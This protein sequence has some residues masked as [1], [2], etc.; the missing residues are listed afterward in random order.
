MIETLTPFELARMIAKK[1]KSKKAPRFNI[2]AQFFAATYC[3]MAIFSDHRAYS[4]IIKSKFSE[5][6]IPIA[7]LN[8]IKKINSTIYVKSKKINFEIILD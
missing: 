1:I 4:F 5:L 3:Y 2:G 7:Y 8:D 6:I